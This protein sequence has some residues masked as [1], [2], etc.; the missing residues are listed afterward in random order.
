MGLNVGPMPTLYNKWITYIIFAVGALRA[1]LAAGVSSK[2]VETVEGTQLVEFP[3]CPF[4][5]AVAT[6][7][8]RGGRE[9]RLPKLGRPN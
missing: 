5:S 7:N 2:D 6:L 9:F 3:I 4:L 1:F 8:L